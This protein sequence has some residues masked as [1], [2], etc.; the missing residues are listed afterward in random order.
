MHRHK[1]KAS[2]RTIIMLC[3]I[4]LVIVLAVWK[5]WGKKET[6]TI[7]RTAHVQ[8][9]SVLSTVSANGVLQPLST[10][11]LKSNVGGQVTQLL[12]DEGDR[13]RKGQLIANI[14]PTDTQTAY[15][16]SVADMAASQSKV[17]QAREQLSVT[18]TQTQSEITTARE[19]LATA[20]SQLALA[21]EQLRIQP[22]LTKAS[23]SKAESAYSGAMTSYEQLKSVTVPQSL[24]D[25]QSSYDQ[26]K[27]AS[28][29]AQLNLQRQRALLDKGFVS[30]SDVDN[31]EESNTVAQAQLASAKKKLDNI[32]TNNSQQLKAAEL[33]L[34]EA[35]Q[36]LQSA[37]LNAIDIKAKQQALTSAKAS[38]KQ[39]EAN[40][41]NALASARQTEIRQGDIIQANA[42][43][44]RSQAALRSNKIQLGYT[45][46]TAPC[47]GVVT[48]KYVEAG[49][50]VTA[51]RSSFSGSGNGVGIVDIADI[52]RMFALVS[53]DETDIASIHVGQSVKV[54]IEAYPDRPVMGKVTKI[55]AQSATTQSVTTIPV[56]VELSKTNVRYK[57]GMNVACDF[58]IAEAN[59]VLTVPNEAIKQGRRSTTVTVIK[60]GVQTER[61]VTV[62]LTGTDDTEIKSGLRNGEE[63]VTAVIE[64]KTTPMTPGGNQPGGMGGP[65]MGGPGMGGAG[66]GGGGGRNRG[67]F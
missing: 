63:V 8:Q 6:D 47:D 65:G 27:A 14:D 13:V 20:K 53:V 46:I 44:Q 57:P 12:V 56:T 34:K 29:T 4:V 62:G 39:A 50:I 66:M 25:A 32:E 60:D 48:A 61:K 3:V 7:I 17:Q 26:A 58:I 28:K 5:P 41:Q 31:A 36:D 18:K 24:I 64:M 59:N 55:A 51:G 9:G 35:E 10:V 52:S 42:Q 23:I 16:Q 11:Q 21:Q 67:R 38:V 2:L 22:S 30:K 15:D 37:K 1:G 33:K 54:T 43:V 40:L 19:A 45:T 49:S